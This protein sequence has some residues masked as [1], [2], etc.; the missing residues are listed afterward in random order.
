MQRVMAEREEVRLKELPQRSGFA[1]ASGL[2]HQRGGTKYGFTEAELYR[3]G[4][5]IYTY[6]ERQAQEA[7]EAVFAET[8]VSRHRSMTRRWKV[9][10]SFSTTDRRH[11]GHGGRRGICGQGH[12]LGDP[13]GSAAAA[14]PSS[15]LPYTARRWRRDG[16]RMTRLP[17]KKMTYKEYGNWTPTNAGGRYR[18]QVT[19]M[20]AL[21]HSSTR[22]AAWLLNELGPRPAT[23]LPSAWGFLSMRM[24]RHNLAISLG[25]TTQGVSPLDMAQAYTAFANNGTLMRAIAIQEITSG[26]RLFV[27]VEAGRGPVMNVQSAIT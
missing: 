24:H 5:K 9:P 2:Y 19:M 26:R 6:M 14:P 21:T 15:P 12:Q 7:L 27:R 18:G 20:T 25:G 8:P 16:S 10:W 17:D 13:A 4:Y 3:G 23:I 1:Q 22:P 11:R